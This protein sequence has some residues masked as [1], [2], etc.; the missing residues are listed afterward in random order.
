VFTQLY[1][2]HTQVNYRNLHFR[3]L[4]VT[5]LINNAGLLSSDPDIA[6]PIG[7]QQL[8]AYTEI[9]YDV[10]PHILPDTTHSLMPWFRYSWLDTQNDMPTGFTR[11]RTQRRNFYEVGM[12]YKPIPQVVLKAEYSIADSQGGSLPDGLQLGGGFV[13]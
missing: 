11:D 3:A 10:L 4:G 13:F 7:K 6:G 9:G 1:E 12:Q 5:T 2:V 8:G